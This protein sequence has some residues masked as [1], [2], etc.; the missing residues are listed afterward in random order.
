LKVAFPEKAVEADKKKQYIDRYKAYRSKDTAAAGGVPF[1]AIGSAVPDLPG[2]GAE[3]GKSVSQLQQEADGADVALQQDFMTVMSHT[4]TAEDYA[5]MQEEGFDLGSMDPEDVVTIVDKIKAELVR[6]GQNIVGYT[7]DIDMATLTA[8]LGS[9]TLAQAVADSFRTADVPLT[10]ENLSAISQAWEMNTQ[11]QPMEDGARSYLIDNE[12]ETEI[13][14][15][16]LAQNSGAGKGGSAPKFYSEDVRGYYA[17]NAGG[18]QELMNN[19]E[20]LA[21]I[22]K[23]IRQSGREVNDESHKDASWLLDRGLPLTAENLNKLA[24]LQNL[25][26]PVKEE[27]FAQTAAAA[28]AEGKNPMHASLAKNEENL[29]E[30][31]AELSDYYHSRE[32]WEANVGDITARR[33]MEEVRLRMTAEVNVKLLKRGFAIDT[34]PMEEL[35]EALKMAERQVAD[36]YFPKDSDAVDKYRSYHR[37]NTVASDLPKLPA[38]VLG[39]FAKGHNSASLA[40]FHK[41]GKA[42]QETYEKAQKSYETLMTSPRSDLGDSIQKAFSNT[43]NLLQ[44]LG[45]ELTDENRRAV[46]ILGYNQMEVN[47]SNLEAVKEADRLV[48]SV[49]EK[50]TPAATLKMIR[51]GINPLEKTFGELEEY[52]EKLPPEYKKD[53]ESYSRFLYGLERNEEITPE[54]RESYI[55]IFRLVRQL[56]RADGAAVGALVNSQAELQFANLLSAVRSG[57]IKNVDVR[58]TEELT[59]AADRLKKNQKTKK[60]DSISSQIAKAFVKTANKIVSAVSNTQNAAEEYNKEQLESIRMAVTTA[61]KEC[62]AML[63]R[64]EMTASADN[65]MAAQ[66]LT[67]GR[68]NIFEPGDKRRGGADRKKNVQTPKSSPAQAAEKTPEP[69]APKAPE[70]VNVPRREIK[71]SDELWEILDDRDHFVESYVEMAK[72]ALEAVEDNTF[73]E[74]ESSLDVRSM[75]LTHKQ[76]TVA[77]SLARQEEFF[78]PL[79]VG[80]TL[81]QVHLTLDRNSPEKGTVTVGI[82]PSENDYM[83][84]RIYLERGAVYGIFMGGTQNEVM[85][86]QEIADTFKK[87]AGRNWEMGNITVIP[88]GGG[89]PDFA[90]AGEHNQTENAELYRV[91]KVFLHSVIETTARYR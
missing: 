68:D 6:S 77:A 11:L 71:S 75:Q 19:T 91:A 48:Q 62:V 52:F 15:L 67:H 63:E 30:R 41:T 38:D 79:Y 90:R 54:E 26:L 22:D 78:L 10:K 87:E 14:N 3:K 4:M 89:M 47:M 80:D 24:D 88:S 64:G 12:L 20:L 66:A 39:T 7:D 17:Q 42:L 59:T 31:A 60:G 2:M 85:K 43:D 72:S 8:A 61:D 40:E 49:I 50:L 21:Q 53:A 35:I 18:G 32:F 83:Q 76:L 55:G 16:Y 45:A 58:V 84:A 82:A 65:L 33:Q 9:Q 57:R 46:R 23:V 13:F 56:E 74:A 86:M 34:A 70:P 29:Y 5:K 1:A 28:V 73:T 81:T 25:S 44:N 51:D 37:T 69:P 27:Q 36:R